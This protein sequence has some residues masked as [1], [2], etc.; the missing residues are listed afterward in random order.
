MCRKYELDDNFFDIPD[1]INSYWAGF[2]AADG[3]ISQRSDCQDILCIKLNQKDFNH[4]QL[5]QNTIKYKGTIYKYNIKNNS[6]Y[7]NFKSDSSDMCILRM[8][9]D[10]MCFDLSKNYNI[11]PKKSLILKPPNI[12]SEQTII[13]FIVGYIDGDGCI[14]YMK[15][16]SPAINIL[17]THDMMIWVRENLLKIF[18]LTGNLGISKYK[19]QTV[20]RIL[21]LGDIKQ[22]YD[23]IIEH[24]IPH[25]ER[26][27]ILFKNYI[28][29]NP[30]KLN[31]KKNSKRIL[32][33]GK[34]QSLKE[35]S[36]EYNIPLKTLWS[37]LYSQK[38]SMEKSLKTPLNKSSRVK[39]ATIGDDQ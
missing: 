27:W 15:N 39:N 1:I 14:Y 29:N 32:Y 19:K 38:W 30:E 24:D 11:V 17:G 8:S 12:L 18:N 23:Y 34:I 2:I 9:S 22:I 16:G 10:K 3:C 28:T 31:F 25:L 5:F 13:S 26:K 35:W 21:S 36:I 33:D 6:K 20:L 37:R 7:L 4:L